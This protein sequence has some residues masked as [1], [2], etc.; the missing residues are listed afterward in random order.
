MDVAVDRTLELEVAFIMAANG[1]CLASAEQADGAA[2]EHAAV[3]L[4]VGSPGLVVD[5]IGQDLADVDRGRM[6]RIDEERDS[7]GERLAVLLA[8]VLVGLF[9]MLLERGGALAQRQ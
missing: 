8:L 7:A 3:A 1:A 2:R 9:D 4:E 5:L 6:H